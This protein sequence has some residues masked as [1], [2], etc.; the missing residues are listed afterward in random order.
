MKT[1]RCLHKRCPGAGNHESLCGP[2][3]LRFCLSVSNALTLL[4]KRTSSNHPWSRMTSSRTAYFPPGCYSYAIQ[5]RLVP[6]HL[7]DIFHPLR[8]PHAQCS[9]M[10]NSFWNSFLNALFLPDKRSV[11][12]AQSGANDWSGQPDANFIFCDRC[13][14]RIFFHESIHEINSLRLSLGFKC[15]DIS[16]AQVLG[17]H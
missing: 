8:L 3:F 5:V 2:Y 16:Y 1:T 14:I 17:Q 15:P 12:S 10:W 7:S 9:Q 11:A 6:T 4:C 13:S